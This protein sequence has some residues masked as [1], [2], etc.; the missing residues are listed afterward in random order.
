MLPTLPKEPSLSEVF[1]NTKGGL[2]AIFE[3][4][5]RQKQE[6]AQRLAQHQGRVQETL[7][8]LTGQRTT[9]PESFVVAAKTFNVVDGALVE[10][11]STGPDFTVT[12]LTGADAHK[13]Q[14]TMPTGYEKS[15]LAVYFALDTPEDF[16]GLVTG[17]RQITPPPVTGDVGMTVFQSGNGATRQF[18]IGDARFVPDTS[19]APVTHGDVYHVPQPVSRLHVQLL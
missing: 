2:G 19:I 16:A 3:E 1:K 6:Q 5:D 11:F 12:A 4:Y 18:W 10:T 8:T 13:F 7:L 17:V 14:V 15:A 9:T